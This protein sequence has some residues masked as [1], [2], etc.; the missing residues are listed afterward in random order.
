MFPLIMQPLALRAIRIKARGVRPSNRTCQSMVRVKPVRSPLVREVVYTEEH[1]QLLNSLRKES[2]EVIVALES[3]GIA[4]YLHGS[5]ARGD[6]NAKSDIDVVIMDVM[7]S[8]KVELAL[9]NIGYDPEA[10]LIAMATPSHA[11][12]AIIELRDRIIVTFPLVKLLR[13]E[14]E[15]YRFGGI[16]SVS[17]VKSGVRKPGVDKRLV[18]IEPT[19]KGH[20]AR[21]LIGCETEVAKKLGI[22]IDMIKERERVLLRRD[23]VGRTGVYVRKHVPPDVTIEEW[24]DKIISENPPASMKLRRKRRL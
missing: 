5:V 13:L 6:V 2:T 4:T 1:F 21:S 18:F 11:L 7:P 19:E 23:K 17:E 22:S 15:F 8:Y 12:K 10:R 20:I 3:E 24:A 16:C 9:S 14:R